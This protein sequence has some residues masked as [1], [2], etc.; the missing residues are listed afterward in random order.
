MAPSVTPTGVI[1]REGVIRREMVAG[2]TCM[3]RESV[4]VAAVM[5]E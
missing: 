3:V 5:S 2:E 1:V 4:C